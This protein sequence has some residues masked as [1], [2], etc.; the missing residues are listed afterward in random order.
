M[1]TSEE[2]PTPQPTPEVENEEIENKESFFSTTGNFFLEVLKVVII[3]LIIILPVRYFLIQPFYVR[4][5]SMEPNFHEYEYL[6]IDELSYRLGEPQRGDVVVLKDPRDSSQ[7]FIKRLIGLPG[8]EVHI[9]NGVIFIY[10]TDHPDGMLLDE[11]AYLDSKVTTSG[12][13]TVTVPEN[14]FYVLGDNRP[15]SLDSRSIGAVPE[16]FIIGRVLVRAWPF[17]RLKYYRPLLY[18]ANAQ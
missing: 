1:F 7:Y 2:T 4:G 10:N 8:E 18:P 17:H 13:I 15:A 11:S 14:S 3:A 5:A 9:K 12:N 6:I 16:N